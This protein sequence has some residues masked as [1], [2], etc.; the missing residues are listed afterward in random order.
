MSYVY[1]IKHK[2][3]NKK[4]IG[5]KYSKYNCDPN[6][7]L[8][9]NGYHTSSNIIKEIIKIDGL[10]SF[11]IIALRNYTDNNSVALLEETKFLRKWNIASRL[12]WFNC[13]NNETIIDDQ[14]NLKCKKYKDIFSINDY[15]KMMSTIKQNYWNTYGNKE[16]WSEKLKNK[17]DN[18]EF[19]NSDGVKKHWSIQND[20][21]ITE[22]TKNGLLIAN[23]KT[24]I[25]IYCNKS[26]LTIG[27]LKRW[28]NEKC[29]YSSK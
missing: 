10:D 26:G 8:K 9:E 5:C 22:R 11:E 19:N 17:W 21:Y 4:Y 1:I 16:Q 25:C 23:S 15:S 27:N 18:G 13:H 24:H 6:D 20:E 7:L 28:H 29:K 12:D 2:K 14:Y 3:S